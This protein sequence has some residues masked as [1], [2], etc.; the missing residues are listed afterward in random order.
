MCVCSR[1]ECVY[2]HIEQVV[3]CDH[4]WSH[5]TFCDIYIYMLNSCLDCYAH[6][7]YLNCAQKQ[8]EM[9]SLLGE[10]MKCRFEDCTPFESLDFHPAGRN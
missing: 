8:Q 9:R 1:D 3:R 4:K 5:V 6:T 2:L 7:V 10:E